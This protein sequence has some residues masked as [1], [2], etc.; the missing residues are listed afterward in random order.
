MAN[1]EWDIGDG[2]RHFRNALTDKDKERLAGLATSGQKP[3]TLVIGCSDSRADPTLIFSARQGDIFSVRNV[4]N[5]VP[6]LEMSGT[7]HG[8]C[9]A[10]EYAICVLDIER[11]VILGH[12][13]CGGIAA[14]IEGLDQAHDQPLQYVGP[15]ISMI[16]Q[17][18]M[19]VEA[20]HTDMP[21]ALLK[22]ELERDSIKQSVKNLRSYSF[23]TTAVEKRNLKIFGAWFEIETQDLYVLDENEGNFELY[24]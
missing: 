4:A 15:W 9:A 19:E 16:D 7:Y 18:R 13:G 2:Y 11:I 12:S 20:R 24:I 1:E 10:I 8:T 14:A 5:L 17:I 6:P 3:T 21:Q 22:R 23:V